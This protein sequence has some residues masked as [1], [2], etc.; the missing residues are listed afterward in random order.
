MIEAM[1]DDGVGLEQV[2]GHAGAVADVVAHVV[3]DRRRVVFPKLN[4]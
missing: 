3:G 4:A 1:N 2:R